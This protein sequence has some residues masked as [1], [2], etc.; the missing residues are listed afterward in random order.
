VAVKTRQGKGH[1]RK[2]APSWRKRGTSSTLAFQNGLFNAAGHSGDV[3]IKETGFPFKPSKKSPENSVNASAEKKKARSKFP[4]HR[5]PSPR[6]VS[7]VQMEEKK[8]K[9]VAAIASSGMAESGGKTGN[10]TPKETTPTKQK[11]SQGKGG[12]KTGSSPPVEMASQAGPRLH[13]KTLKKEERKELSS[14]HHKQRSIKRPG[15]L[16]DLERARRKRGLP[17]GS[18]RLGTWLVRESLGGQVIVNV[19][20]VGGLRR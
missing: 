10:S 13:P 18:E 7:R 17:T 3:R 11:T 14:F 6:Q 8:E 1:G 2:G 16:W 19:F 12:K 15:R 5:R 9:A 4:E 20:K